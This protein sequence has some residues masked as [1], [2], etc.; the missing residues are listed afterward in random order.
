MPKSGVSVVIC[1]YNSANKIIKTLEHL[2]VQKVDAAIDWEIILVNNNSTDA[3]VQ[4]AEDFWN[5]NKAAT[6]LRII[7]EPNPGLSFA[8]KKKKKN[9]RLTYVL[10]SDDDN[11]L[12]NNY[13]QLA[14]EIM[15]SN[16]SIGVLG[17]QG[18]AV[19]ESPA[20]NWFTTYQESYAVG[21]QA[22]KTGDITKRGYVWG[23]GF[24]LNR[25]V[26]LNLLDVGFTFYCSD[27]KGNILSSGGDSEICKWFVLAG[28][29][30]WYSEE[31]KY[32]HYMPSERLKKE[33]YNKL[34]EAFNICNKYLY[35]YELLIY[36][37]ERK[38]SFNEKALEFVK[39]IFD[40]FWTFIF[41]P[42][43]KYS[44]RF[45]LQRLFPHKNFFIVDK[46]YA[47]IYKATTTC[48]KAN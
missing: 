13:I 22:L 24:I 12:A 41:A 47:K 23:A 10:F 43:E 4:V 40:F 21:V 3:T 16:P 11:W 48:R 17:G 35:K 15:T 44:I 8:R 42:K 6:N 31:L 18:E 28:Y 27:R 45:N 2:L 19:F 32:W 34:L 1:C 38:K 9:A 33:Y 5:E 29:K 26:L 30:L 46:I 7:N 25:K 14:Y 37:L 36:D 39:L 20:P